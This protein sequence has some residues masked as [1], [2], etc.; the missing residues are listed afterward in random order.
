[1]VQTS[2]GCP[3]RPC[4]HRCGL[5]SDFQS[6]VRETEPFG[7][8]EPANS[9]E[10]RASQRSGAP[11]TLGYANHEVSGRFPKGCTPK[12]RF[13]GGQPAWFFKTPFPEDYRSA[14][15]DWL[16]RRQDLASLGRANLKHVREREIPG[17]NRT[18]CPA[19]VKVRAAE[20]PL[21]IAHVDPTTVCSILSLRL[22][23]L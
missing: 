21:S 18:R 20:Q 8:A 22:T 19:R 6:S 3:E 10:T 5:H 1:M 14:V 23:T 4:N 7:R 2:T 11:V 15:G 16:M 13:H 12:E 17:R 9:D